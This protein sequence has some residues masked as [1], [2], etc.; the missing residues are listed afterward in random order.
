MKF[1]I[2]QKNG[3]SLISTIITIIV[4]V[5]IIGA[6]SYSSINGF[7]LKKI[8]NFYSDI[9]TVADAVSVYYLKN[10]KL[11]IYYTSFNTNGTPGTY[12]PL[13]CDN[14]YFDIPANAYDD[15]TSYGIVDL[16]KLQNISLNNNEYHSLYAP[17]DSRFTSFIKLMLFIH[18]RKLFFLMSSVKESRR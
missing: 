4:L 5:I 11:P 7:K 3:L 18:F 17:P 16:S 2:K 12:Q 14:V 9:D 1:D 15:L 13:Y 10:E 8:K 6:I